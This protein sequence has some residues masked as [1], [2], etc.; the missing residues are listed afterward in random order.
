MT[1]LDPYAVLRVA[2][3]APWSTIQAAYRALARRHHPDIAGETGIGEMRR[4]NAAWEILRD[5]KR[6]A[7]YDALHPQTGLRTGHGQQGRTGPG[8]GHATRHSTGTG[9]LPTRDPAGGARRAT[10]WRLGPDGIGAA[11]PPPGRPSGS[12]LDFGRF[13]GWSLGEVARVDP[14]Y[15][16]WL[17]ARRDGRPYLA[18]IDSIL[19]AVGFRQS[20]GG[21]P[22]RTRPRGRR[23]LFGI[24]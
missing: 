1:D 13:I 21:G 24:G 9:G 14:G 20:P 18:E 6:R 22:A 10:G 11:G 23:R 19:K 5:P 7:A 12:I 3:D 8:T 17:E 15:L 4:I 16:E 2:S